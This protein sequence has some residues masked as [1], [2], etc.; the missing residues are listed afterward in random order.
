M[1]NTTT[2]AWQGAVL[3]RS[4]RQMY[5]CIPGDWG[6]GSLALTISRRSCRAS[7]TTLFTELRFHG[8]LL[9]LLSFDA[10]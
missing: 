9:S 10:R 4:F 8:M 7:P 3:K 5:D 2:S 1:S 6:S